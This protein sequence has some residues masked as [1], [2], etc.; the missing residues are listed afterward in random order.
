MLSHEGKHRYCTTLDFLNNRE[1]VGFY[2]VVCTLEIV[3]EDDK[4]SKGF[5]DL[6]NW[7]NFQVDWE[8]VTP[9]V[10]HDYD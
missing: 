7:E 5:E 9:F 2:G 10:N 6:K 3:L 8:W 4:S 1:S